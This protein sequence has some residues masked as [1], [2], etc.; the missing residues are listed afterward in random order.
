MYEA[1]ALRSAC[2]LIGIFGWHFLLQVILR[3]D[4]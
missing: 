1:E 3:E 4:K 2:L